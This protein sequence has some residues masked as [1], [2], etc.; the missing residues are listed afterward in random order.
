MIKQNDIEIFS[1]HALMFGFQLNNRGQNIDKYL[2]R[3]QS[4]SFVKVLQYQYKRCLNS[5]ISL[6]KWVFHFSSS[7]RQFQFVQ[8]HF[9]EKITPGFCTSF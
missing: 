1:K 2:K 9:P 5:M 4:F 8:N 6:I 3:G 7:L